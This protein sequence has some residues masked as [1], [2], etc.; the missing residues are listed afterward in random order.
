M[1]SIFENN[2]DSLTHYNYNELFFLLINL[3]SFNYSYQKNLEFNIQKNNVFKMLIE[4]V[5]S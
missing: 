1:K 5:S 4:N 3:V 2:R